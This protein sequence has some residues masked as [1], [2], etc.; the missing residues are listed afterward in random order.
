[1]FLEFS[2][3]N[4]TTGAA[5]SKTDNVSFVNFPGS[6][7][8]KEI[9]TYLDGKPIGALTNDFVCFKTYIENAVS[10]NE[11][12]LK[13]LKPSMLGIMDESARFDEVKFVA[14]TTTANDKDVMEDYKDE[15][16]RNFGF[17]K[18][19]RLMVKDYAAN[20]ANDGKMQTYIQFPCDYWNT[21]MF[22]PPGLERFSMRVTRTSDKFFLLT[23]TASIVNNYKVKVHALRLYVRFTDIQPAIMSAHQNA[24]AQNKMITIPFNKTVVKTH[25]VYPGIKEI[26][27]PNLY[28]GISLPK[29]VIIVFCSNTQVDGAYNLNPMKFHHYNI[30]ELYLKMDGIRAIPTDYYTPNFEKNKAVREYQMF[31]DNLGLKYNDVSCPITYDMYLNGCTMF[32]FDLTPD[33]CA[34]YHR[35]EKRAGNLDLYVKMSANLDSPMYIMAFATYDAVLGID[36]SMNISV[37]Y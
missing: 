7:F 1:M 2:V 37:D 33:A 32:S 20:K 11:Q 27:H 16:T 35:H 9:E 29:T 5:I 14:A 36:K 25:L 4:G 34:G 3:V 6:S 23:D 18:R 21:I 30:T 8:I 31:M 10:Y 15:D 28:A 12:T 26:F 13:R 22:F 17:V 24:L 19:R